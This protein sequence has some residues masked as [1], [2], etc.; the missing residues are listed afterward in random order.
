MFI[1]SIRYVIQIVQF[2]VDL[3]FID[4]EDNKIPWRYKDSIH[5][6]ITILG[7]S[8]QSNRTYQFMVQM[9]SRKHAS[10][11]TKG[12]I[13]VQVEDGTVPLITIG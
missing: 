7:G 10:E 5:S 11:Q 6:S 3:A 1:E 12:Y 9:I 2:I 13:L 8:L 4:D